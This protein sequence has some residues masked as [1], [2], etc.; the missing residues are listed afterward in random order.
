MSEEAKPILVK[1]EDRIG[2]IILN[3]P[4]KLNAFT[5]EMLEKLGAAIDKFETD[6]EV[7]CVV[8]TGT[9]DRAF[10]TGADIS[11]FLEMTPAS[12]EKWSKERQDIMLKLE[13]MSKPVIA[14]I[15][16]YC[17]GGGLELAVACDFRIA[18]ENAQLGNPEINLGLIAGWGGTQRLPR[19]IGVA[20]A[21]ELLML[22]SRVPAQEAL[23]IGLV[24]MVVP[25]EK[26]LEEAKALATKLLAAPPIALRL[27][28]YAVNFGSEAPLDAG[29]RI[30]A[31]AF[32][33]LISTEDAAEGI[34]AFLSRRKAVFKGK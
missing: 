29:L 3:R 11:G 6:G 15:N 28:K 33:M 1:K 22:G 25:K 12:A 34:N 9:G 2:W 30:E 14:A 4:E 13:N 31:E 26:L 8:I 20:K 18:S 21:K 23:R 10:C 27:T 17:L 24:H 19:I 32:G 5:D 7:G 16:G